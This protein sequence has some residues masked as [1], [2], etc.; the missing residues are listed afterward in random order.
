VVVVV[1]VVVV[2]MNLEIGGRRKRAEHNGH[3]MEK[4]RSNDKNCT[5]N[6]TI[7]I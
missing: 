6:E 3:V 5:Q 7:N 2:V 1:V 4:K